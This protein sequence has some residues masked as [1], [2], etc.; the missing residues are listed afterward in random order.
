MIKAI[1]EKYCKNDLVQLMPVSS[2]SQLITS[3][4]E[5]LFLKVGDKVLIN[6]YE[7]H[8]SRSLFP[9]SDKIKHSGN[10]TQLFEYNK[11]YLNYRGSFSGINNSAKLFF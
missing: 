8:P 3:A 9:Y 2:Q 11:Q 7:K 1:D 10:Y 5:I 4:D 6:K